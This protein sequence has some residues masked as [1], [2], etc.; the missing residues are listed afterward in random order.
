[1]IFEW[2]DNDAS[3]DQL[4]HGIGFHETATICGDP[5]AV[6]FEDHD[7]SEIEEWKGRIHLRF[8]PQVGRLSSSLLQETVQSESS[9]RTK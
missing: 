9:V 6:I 7:H 5:L 1:M 4:K 8:L 3:K 2:D